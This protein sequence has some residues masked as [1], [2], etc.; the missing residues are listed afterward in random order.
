MTQ[1]KKVKIVNFVY[2]SMIYILLGFILYISNLYI[3]LGTFTIFLLLFIIYYICSNLY[4]YLN[5]KKFYKLFIIQHNELIDKVNL[6][7]IDYSFKFTFWSS[8][9]FI[10]IKFFIIRG[11]NESTEIFLNTY[12]LSKPLNDNIEE[13]EYILNLN[14]KIS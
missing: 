8:Y 14:N 1:F 7:V 12:D 11:N 9:K 6:K 3:N 2:S 4:N 5:Y 13:Y 10:D